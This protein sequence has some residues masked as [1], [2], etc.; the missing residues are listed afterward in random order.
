MELNYHDIDDDYEFDFE[1]MANSKTPK[2]SHATPKLVDSS[3]IDEDDEKD[4]KR[5]KHNIKKVSNY[6][7]LALIEKTTQNL[8]NVEVCV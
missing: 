5:P 3:Q 2:T 4:S 7:S 8:K 6:V 1:D